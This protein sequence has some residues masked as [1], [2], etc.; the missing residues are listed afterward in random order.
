MTT[1]SID[2]I[3]HELQMTFHD[4]DR[5]IIRARKL[6]ESRRTRGRHV[7]LI[8]EQTDILA[9]AADLDDRLRAHADYPLSEWRDEDLLGK[10]NSKSQELT[11]AM[12][13][14]FPL[15]PAVE[16]GIPITAVESALRAI[17]ERPGELQRKFANRM[18]LLTNNV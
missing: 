5:L 2:D 6:P 11:R 8:D 15:S 18:R 12:A 3:A 14:I 16:E 13:T 17:T 9:N 4:M 1:Q 7:D 10:T